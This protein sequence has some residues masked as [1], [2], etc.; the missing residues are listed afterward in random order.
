MP[1]K[2]NLQDAFAG[3]SQ[4]NRKYTAF[5][6]KAEADGYPQVAKLFNAA[7][8][9]ETVHALSHFRVMDGIRSTAENLKAAIEGEGYEYTRMYPEFLKNAEE[10]G[11]K[12]AQITFKNAL[13]VEEE[14]YGLYQQALAVVQKGQDLPDRKLY[15]CSVCGNTTYDEAPERCPVCQAAK[16][17]FSEIC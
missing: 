2:E 8:A 10:E 5:A 17:K 3:E 13:A 6:K 14:H 11:N 15:V 1:T 4:A 9:A 7:A 16:A 12:A